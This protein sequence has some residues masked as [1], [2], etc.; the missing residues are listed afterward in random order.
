MRASPR[1]PETAELNVQKTLE[2]LIPLLSTT[3]AGLPPLWQT[4]Y[5]EGI[6]SNHLLFAKADLSRLPDRPSSWNHED[7]NVVVQAV[8]SLWM[9]GDLRAMQSIVSDLNHAQMGL[10][11]RLYQHA[12]EFWSRRTRQS[13]N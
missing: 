1:G 7:Q 12:L 10:F 9:A 5:Y 6:R 11:Y 3:G 13:L 4:L 8:L 2:S